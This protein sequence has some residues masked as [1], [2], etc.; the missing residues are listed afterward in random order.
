MELTFRPATQADFDDVIEMLGPKRRPD[1]Q[2]CW[3]LTYRLGAKASSKLDAQQRRDL[4]FQLCGHQPAPGVLAYADGEVVG[5]AGIAPRA[6]VAELANTTIYPRVDDIE[7]WSVFCLRTRAGHRRQG[8][9]NQLLAGAVAFAHQHGATVI[10]AYP[11]DTDQKVDAIYTYPGLRPMFERAGFVKVAD[12]ASVLGGVRRIVM[13]T[14]R[15]D[16]R[17]PSSRDDQDGHSERSPLR[18]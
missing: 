2:A 6:E 5:W 10:E 17:W 12:T 14:R 11:L 8:I 16:A 1:A 13:R 3:C 18:H 15:R 9:G 4:V 7:P